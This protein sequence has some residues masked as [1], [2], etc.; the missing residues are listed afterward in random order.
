MTDKLLQ[1]ADLFSPKI[2]EA[3]LQSYREFLK[4][5]SEAEVVSAFKRN[6]LY[7]LIELASSIEGDLSKNVAP[8]LYDT[9]IKSGRM[10]IEVLPQ[11]SLIGFASFSTLPVGAV[12][13]AE[14]FRAALVTGL[15]ETAR[16]TITTAVSLNIAAGNNPIKTAR[17]FRAAI[18]L[19]SPQWNAV[20]NYRSLLENLDSE[21]LHREWRDARGDSTVRG[22]IESGTP[23]SE[24]R[25]D[26]LTERYRQRALKQRAE[27]IARTESLRAV[28]MGEYESILAAH[29]EGKIS[30]NLRRFWIVS[31]DERVR[32]YHLPIPAMNEAGV[33]I[34]ESFDTPLGPMRYPLD[35]EGSAANVVNCRCRLRYRIIR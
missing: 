34:D 27:T 30:P 29:M 15:T 9:W 23:L 16:E 7:G 19:T 18:G 21:A 2:R 28:H 14:A 31:A 8:L 22:A 1:I 17:D 33:K 6:G 4:R 25:I 10:A 32:K 26:W 13:A 35:P 20:Q 24:E 12:S 3:L 5:V 11:G